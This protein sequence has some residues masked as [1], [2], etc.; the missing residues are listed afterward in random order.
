MCC[1]LF[2]AW[3]GESRGVEDSPLKG[4]RVLVKSYWISTSFLVTPLQLLL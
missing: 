3:Q 1:F 4:K 2:A